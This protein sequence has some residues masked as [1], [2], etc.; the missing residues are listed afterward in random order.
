MTDLEQTHDK[1]EI[2]LFRVKALTSTHI[3]AEKSI[4]NLEY[5]KLAK[6]TKGYQKPKNGAR[7]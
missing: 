3:G 5:Q 6:S 2:A 4:E 7:A 1:I